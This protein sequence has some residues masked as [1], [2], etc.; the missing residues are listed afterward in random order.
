MP[1]K[2]RNK[3]EQ[4]ATTEIIRILRQSMPTCAVEVKVAQSRKSGDRL[5]RSQVAPHQW[6]ALRLAAEGVLAYKIPD[7]G[8]SAKPFDLF[9]MRGVPAYVCAVFGRRFYLVPWRLMF[10]WFRENRSADE[11]VVGD[12]SAHRG[13][14]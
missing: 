9:V 2:P 11:L 4:A 1:P 10:E 5:C 14:F 12:L 8:V 3:R 6:N 7:E 13:A